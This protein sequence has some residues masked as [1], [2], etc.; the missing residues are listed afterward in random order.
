MASLDSMLKSREITLPT[1]VLVVKL[2]PGGISDCASGKQPICQCRRRKRQGLDPWVEKICWRRKWKPTPVFLPGES[3]GQRSLEG[4]SPVSQWVQ[5]LERHNW[6]NLAHMHMVFPAVR[7]GCESWTL[8]KAQHQKI[9]ALEL[10]CWTILLRIPW[11][12]RKSN[13][14]ILKEINLNIYWRDW[15]WSWSSNPGHLMR[16]S[17]SLE[18]ILMLGKIEGKKRKWKQKMRWLDSIND[19][20]VMNMSPLWEIRTRKPGML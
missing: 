5:R 14:P 9:N 4:Y 3:Y 13:Q 10:W 16:Q 17:D 1:K 6:N 12:A 18:K 20:M 8:K 2:F 11:I 19:S 7:Y 15:C